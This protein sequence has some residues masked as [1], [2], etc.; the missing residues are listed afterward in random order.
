MN[1]WNIFIRTGRI[2]DYLFYKSEEDTP[3]GRNQEECGNAGYS[4]DDRSDFGGTDHGRI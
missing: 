4:V 1:T 2:A 3:A